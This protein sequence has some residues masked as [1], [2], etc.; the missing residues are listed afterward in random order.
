LQLTEAGNETVP[1]GGQTKDVHAE[2]AAEFDDLAVATA[3]KFI[4]K[5]ASQIR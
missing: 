2:V 5:E 4:A 1:K 3:V